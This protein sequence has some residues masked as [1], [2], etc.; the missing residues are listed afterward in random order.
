MATGIR[1]TIR[2][3]LSMKNSSLSGRKMTNP[4]IRNGRKTEKSKD[5]EGEEKQI[6]HRNL[7]RWLFLVRLVAPTSRFFQEV[8]FYPRATP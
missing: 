8:G 2:N 4:R 6:S 7:R 3:R 1:K 5:L